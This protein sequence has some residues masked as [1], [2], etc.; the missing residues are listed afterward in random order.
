MPAFQVL[1]IW[2]GRTGSSMIGM[3]GDL[4]S[5]TSILHHIVLRLETDAERLFEDLELGRGGLL[6]LLGLLRDLCLRL[7]T[8][9]P[10]AALVG[11][12][13]HSRAESARVAAGT[14]QT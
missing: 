3:P 4:V 10:L 2:Y 6:C 1:E 13:S 7:V 5:G 9:H 14:A 8:G 11:E 12:Q